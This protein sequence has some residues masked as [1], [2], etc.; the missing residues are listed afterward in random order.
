MLRHLIQLFLIAFLLPLAAYGAWWMSR[1]HAADWST[2]DW[3]SAGLLPVARAEPAATV[4]VYAASTGRWKGIFSVHSWLVIKEAGAA[5][6]TRYDVAGWAQ[7]IKVD[8]WPPD[9]RWYGNPPRLIGRVAGPAAERMIPKI[10]A[11]VAAYPARR[12][13]DYRLWPGPNS[14]SF[15]AAIL[16]EVPETGILLPSNAVGRDW[17]GP[18]GLYAGRSPSRTG[19]QVSVFG[20]FGV[21]I[22][23]IEGLELNLLGLV[24]G[25]DW[26]RMA[27]KLPGWGEVRLTGG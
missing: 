8:N 6:Y 20:I 16:A 22:A 9:A 5:K 23:W 13:G 18:F 10:K 26:Q 12:P 25:L 24:T 7:P 3:S 17:R 1:S 2:A 27:L 15:V 19:V 14:N 11:A 4:I 21:T